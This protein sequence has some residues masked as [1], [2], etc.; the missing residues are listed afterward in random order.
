MKLW[1]FLFGEQVGQDRYGNK[2]FVSKHSSSKT[3]QRRWVLFKEK[4]EA[5]AVPAQWHGWLHHTTNDI[6]QSKHDLKY[7]WQ[8][9]HQ[10]NQTGT[11]NAYK[12]SGSLL[13]AANTRKAF[14]TY[15]PW[16]PK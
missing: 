7:T 13:R 8:K 15:Q 5:S 9:D 14:R 1:S 16:Q 11:I 10:A 6:P 12:P 4:P 2:Y 3:P